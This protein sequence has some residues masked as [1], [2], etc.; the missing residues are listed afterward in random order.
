MDLSDEHVVLRK[1]LSVAPWHSCRGKEW[2]WF[3][4][5]NR[6][7]IRPQETNFSHWDY[8][9]KSEIEQY[10]SRC[11]QLRD[12]EFLVNTHFRTNWANLNTALEHC[13]FL[14]SR[15]QPMPME[16]TYPKRNYPVGIDPFYDIRQNEE[17][18]IK[19][20]IREGQTID[21]WGTFI[22]STD[23]DKIIETCKRCIEDL[24][25][26]IQIQDETR[27][28]VQ[29]TVSEY[30]KEKKKST[31]FAAALD[32]YKETDRLELKLD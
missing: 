5:M 11:F 8:I 1:M 30:L 18:P 9:E 25:K 6:R 28:P 12:C 13:D 14:R 10:L 2:D 4:D 16:P 3:V 21:P 7:L 27:P 23:Q 29:M 19:Q 32:Q 17:R 22:G 31:L 26:C 24:D 20:A 15:H